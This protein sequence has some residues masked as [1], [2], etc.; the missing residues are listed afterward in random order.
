MIDKLGI[1]IDVSQ[2]LDKSVYDVAKFSSKPFVACLA[3]LI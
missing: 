2:L 1:I 3:N